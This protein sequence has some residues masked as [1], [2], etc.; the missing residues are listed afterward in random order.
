M[1]DS[2]ETKFKYG[3][4]YLSYIPEGLNVRLIHEIMSQHGEVGRIYLEPEVNNKKRRTYSEGWV[5]F[6]KKRVAKAVA[7]TLNGSP[8]NF[9]K[10]HNKINGQ[11]WS[12][13]YLHRFKWTHLT[14]Q[15]AH[16]RAVMEQKRRF[17]LG[18]AKKHV[19]FYQKMTEKSQKLKKFKLDKVGLDEKTSSKEG[20]LKSQQNKPVEEGCELDV[21]IDEDLLA[22]I[23]KNVI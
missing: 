5:E 23:F 16:D 15:L 4:V 18:Q 2:K 7:D 10:K 1:D 8:L 12:V 17:E 19:D 9:G 6:K 14:E 22:S 13:K 21:Q 20:R 11:I 3:I